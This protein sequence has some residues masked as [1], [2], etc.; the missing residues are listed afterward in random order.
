MACKGLGWQPAAELKQ[1]ELG[2]HKR[3]WSFTQNTVELLLRFLSASFAQFQPL[4]VFL[5][6]H[7]ILF[8]Q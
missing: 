7:V 1:E 5:F 8:A 2:E 3:L 4:I 6:P